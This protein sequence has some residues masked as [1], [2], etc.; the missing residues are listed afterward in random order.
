MSKT[1]IAHTRNYGD[2]NG[3]SVVLAP[4]GRR[5]RLGRRPLVALVSLGV[6]EDSVFRLGGI[7]RHPEVDLRTIADDGELSIGG[8]RVTMRFQSHIVGSSGN[9][10]L[11]RPGPRG[12]LAAER[13]PWVGAYGAE[14][15]ASYRSQYDGREI[16][17]LM[18]LVARAREEAPRGCKG[19]EL[20]R[21]LVGLRR[22]GVEVR[23]WSKTLDAK[24]AARRPA[25]LAVTER[26]AA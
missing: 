12:F 11:D 16:A 3:P 20:L 25:D 18:A 2:R 21:L 9:E 8:P 23:I 15:R 22:C 26:A 19:C 13:G 14:L 17:R 6:A 1:P 4:K 5:A 10:H 7:Y 24:R